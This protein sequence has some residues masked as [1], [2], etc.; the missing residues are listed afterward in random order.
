[1][2]IHKSHTVSE[3]SPIINSCSEDE[4]HNVPENPIIECSSTGMNSCR[5]HDQQN[6]NKPKS[7]KR[8]HTAE[9]PSNPSATK[10][11]NPVNS[12]NAA[13]EN[14]DGYRMESEN[15]NKSDSDLETEKLPTRAHLNRDSSEIH[16]TQQA[17]R[18][19]LS[20]GPNES[21]APVVVL[22]SSTT[23]LNENMLRKTVKIGSELTTAH[24][25]SCATHCFLS[26]K[27][28]ADFTARGLPSYQ[29]RVRYA[30]Q[31][32]TP[33]CVTT[34]IH[35]LPLSMVRNDGNVVAWKATLFIVAD[36]GAD[37]II[38]YPTLRLGGIIDYSPP[39]DYENTLRSHSY[40]VRSMPSIEQA[41]RILNLGKFY[42]YEPPDQHHQV[43]EKPL[44]NGTDG[45]GINYT[46]AFR[47]VVDTTSTTTSSNSTGTTGSFHNETTTT[48]TRGVSGTSTTCTT[49]KGFTSNPTSPQKKTKK[50]SSSFDNT[51]TSTSTTKVS[52]SKKLSETEPYGKN[53][54]LPEEVMEALNYL[55]NLAHGE[56]NTLSC[57]QLQ[58]VQEKLSDKRPS[59][60]NCLTLHDL[61]ETSDKETSLLLHEL[62]DKPRYAKSIFQTSMTLSTVSNFK[63]FEMPQKPGRDEWIPDQPRRYRN[64]A[65]RTVV[66]EWLDTMIANKK[67]RKSN[68]T[69]PAPVTVVERL[70]R[71]PRVCLDYRKRNHR[72]EVPVYPMPDVHDFLDEAAGYE[73][74]CSFDMA[75][76]FTQFRIK[77]EHKH[78]AAFITH[79]GVYEPEV[80]MFGLSGA[81]QHAVREVG[82]SM[83]EDPRTNGVAYTAWAR[84]QNAAGQQP[85]YEICPIT[86]IVKG[87]CLRPF[88]DDVFVKSNH[89][90]GMLKLVELFFEFCYDHHLILTKKKALIMRK[91]LKALGFVV[92]KEGKHLD[93]SRIMTL[94]EAPM[95][96]SKE[97]LHSLLSSYTF[98]RMFIP[99]FASVAAPLYEATRGIVWKGPQSGRS[100]GT[101]TV[102]PEFRWSDE[103][104]RAYDQ[105][106]ASL[107][108]A[109]ILVTPDW[110]LPLF[111]SVDASMRGEGWVL[112]QLIRTAD[113]NPVAAAILYGS[114]KYSDTERK[115]ETTRQEATAIRSALQDVEEYVFGQHF[116]LFSDHLNLRFMHNSVNR[117]VLRMRD[118]LAQFNMTVV[119][120]PGAWNNADP[121]SRLETGNLPVELARDL[122]SST[123][124]ELTDDG[125][126]V[127]EGTDTN[128]DVNS[129]SDII[130]PIR[131]IPSMRTRGNDTLLHYPSCPMQ[132]MNH[133][134]SLCLLCN[135]IEDD[136]SEIE[137]LREPQEQVADTASL[138]TSSDL[139]IMEEWCDGSMDDILHQIL[140]S[141]GSDL[142]DED[143]PRLRI[144]AD[145]WNHC[146]TSYPSELDQPHPIDE[147][148]SEEIDWCGNIDRSSI[149]YCTVARKAGSVPTE[150]TKSVTEP[151]GEIQQREL[152]S[153]ST[154]TSPAD[155]RMATIQ[156]PIV[157][158][159]RAIHNDT[160]GHHGLEFSYRKLLKR[161]GSKWA[162]ER[163]QATK[164][165]NQ[166]KQYIDGCPTCQKL[167][168]LRDKIKCKHSFIISRPF[169]ETSYDF[170]V[171]QRPDKHGNRY[172]I[173]AIDNFTKLVE[174][175]AVANRDAETVAQ[176]LLEIAA[177]YGHCARLRSDNEAA[178]TGQII[179][180]LN[181]NRGTETTPCVPYRPEANSIAERQNAI[182]VFH[183]TALILGCHLGPQTKVGWSE[184][185][186]IVFSI[187]NNTPKNPLGISPLSLVYGVF[188]NY[189]RPLLAPSTNI[190]GAKSN[191]ID[192][193]DTLTDWQTKLLDLAE[194]IQSQ[195][196]ERLDKRFNSG[197]G[198]RQFHQGD[199]VLQQ[200][201]S[202]K[203]TGKPSCKW[204]GPFLVLERRYNDPSHPVLDLMDLTDMTKKEAAADDCRYFNTSW[205]EEDTMMHEISKLAA[206]DLNEYVV[207]K[208]LDHR[209]KGDVRK[210]P[211]SKYFFLVKWEDFEEPTWE[212][213][214]GLKNLE[215]LE[216]YSREHPTL[217]IPI[218][219]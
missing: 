212:P 3:S 64:P 38:G 154:Q 114:R 60:A 142:G 163:G 203:I 6:V 141:V 197:D 160:S 144:E 105:L 73:H 87:S 156:L 179:T 45:T 29:S 173:A 89:K 147:E 98:I 70:G 28:S 208:I 118:F 157:E 159:F 81:P 189:D 216:H 192:Y 79:R 77:E 126:R 205:F 39:D 186:P 37:V 161:C 153:T 134:N 40:A 101:R 55:K 66:D 14:S 207:E 158:D 174:L 41:E 104:I 127:H 63:E 115:W 199:F 183:L 24:L 99:N 102:D 191:P 184:L 211:L 219:R 112:W 176:F 117:A 74:Y 195:H 196:F 175:K 44:G 155:F 72:T 43:G 170:I 7:H 204:I 30:V 132:T 85:P 185:I 31:Q 152:N 194:D 21:D 145:A 12:V 177:R 34:D 68:A 162:N 9:E 11:Q 143:L 217:N 92:S 106:K 27:V 181:K 202:T 171:F 82:G 198:R 103:M 10:M 52:L 69:H 178:F 80:V 139:N 136:L 71:E 113:G 200:K 15:A 182:I 214:N 131:S 26:R 83:A 180:H 90:K 169:L 128:L 190:E 18:E 36:C 95:P 215:P 78:L 168:S 54:P 123:T 48:S 50:T 86:N 67:C 13:G 23:L 19:V 137:D 193:V 2:R 119:H 188:A 146:P 35:V 1:M 94:L 125:Y 138:L 84:E 46:Q 164:I 187:V 51:S 116:Y 148:D 59:W 16:C 109:P 151:K 213:Y 122:N 25:D 56:P 210:L 129:D 93:P 97:T 8:Q 140:K 22:V 120:C 107:L 121:I 20:L 130:V 135:L 75:K 100:K 206:Q 47:T 150:P 167:R 58:E 62:M 49:K 218:S 149:V 124:A 96:R 76:M 17:H 65:T 133:Q 209:P 33:L 61:E 32:G 4:N 165:K 5:K 201:D 42:E 53:P 108:E 172:I 111:L 110:S 91:R 57:S 166:L 88:I